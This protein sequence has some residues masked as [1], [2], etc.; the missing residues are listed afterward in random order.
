MLKKEQKRISGRLITALVLVCLLSGCGKKS[1]FEQ[2]DDPGFENRQEDTQIIASEENENGKNSAYK[3][4]RSEIKKEQENKEISQA[5][6]MPQASEDDKEYADISSEAY[7]AASKFLRYLSEENAEEVL[8]TLFLSDNSIVTAENIDAGIKATELHRFVGGTYTL[9]SCGS[10]PG[11]EY[12]YF[13]ASCAGETS[14]FRMKNTAEGWKVDLEPIYYIYINDME[15][16]FPDSP[17]LTVNGKS[18]TD[19]KETPDQ[20]SDIGIV[21]YKLTFPCYGA[22]V[23]AG[24]DGFEEKRLKLLVTGRKS[25]VYTYD[26]DDEDEKKELSEKAVEILNTLFDC[27]DAD[28]YRC[29]HEDM[30]E[31]ASESLKEEIDSIFNNTETQ[32]ASFTLKDGEPYCIILA[33]DTFGISIEAELSITQDEQDKAIASMSVPLAMK[34]DGDEYK[35]LKIDQ[36]NIFDAIEN[37]SAPK[38]ALDVKEEDADTA[39]GD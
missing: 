9:D 10:K 23:R 24:F 11:E 20:V 36:T 2:Y 19:I 37:S 12:A 8:D 15:V 21:S 3:D 14:M 5:E 29:L 33:Q 39:A 7:K 30:N 4:I 1:P 22:Q 25:G 16:T 32:K 26:V 17:S 13:S 31:E 6:D 34:K 18:I 38:E 35:L 28:R 27:S